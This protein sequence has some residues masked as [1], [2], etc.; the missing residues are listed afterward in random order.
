MEYLSYLGDK[1]YVLCMYEAK[2]SKICNFWTFWPVTKSITGGS[3][4]V[5]VF[6]YDDSAGIITELMDQNIQKCCICP[7]LSTYP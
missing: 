6:T 1:G 5:C 7:M 4:H 3:V 2:N